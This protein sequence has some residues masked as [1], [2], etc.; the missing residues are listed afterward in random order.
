MATYLVT[1]DLKSPGQDYSNLLKRI[2]QHD[3][4][5]LSESSYAVS[6][7]W[8]AETLLDNLREAMDNNDF[9]YVIA[10]HIPW[11]GFGPKETNAWLESHLTSCQ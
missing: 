6:T 8:G 3:H 9:I 11:Y 7:A 5:R 1:Y 4:V 2:R 10:L